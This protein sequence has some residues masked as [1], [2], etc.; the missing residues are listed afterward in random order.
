MMRNIKLGAILQIIA[1]PIAL[2][3]CS[4]AQIKGGGLISSSQLI[5]S[6]RKS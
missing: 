1:L 4:S 3:C 6:G 5:F 2:Y